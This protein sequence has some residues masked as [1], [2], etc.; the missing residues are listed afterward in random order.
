MERS[1][2]LYIYEKMYAIRAFEE[3]VEVLFARGEIPG[4]VHLY[5]GQEACAVGV[6]AN[7][8]PDDYITSTHRGNGH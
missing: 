2:A 4:F 7:L 3:K 5:I 1:T 8:N 6:C